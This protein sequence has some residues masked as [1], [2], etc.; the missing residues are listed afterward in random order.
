[1]ETIYL[2]SCLLQLLIHI[3]K[4]VLAAINTPNPNLRDL[5]HKDVEEWVKS[6]NSMTDAEFHDMMMKDLPD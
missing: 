5:V 6:K 3:A 4:T 1:M 2:F